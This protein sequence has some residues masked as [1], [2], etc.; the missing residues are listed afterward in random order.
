M[1][2]KPAYIRWYT[3]KD[4]GKTPVKSFDRW[5]EKKHTVGSDYEHLII[6]PYS[7]CLPEVA[8]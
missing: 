2:R 7:F 3:F 5:Q 1:N 4:H 6:E 8:D